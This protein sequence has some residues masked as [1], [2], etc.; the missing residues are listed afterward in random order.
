MQL[1]TSHWLHTP[2]ITMFVDRVTVEVEAGRGGDGCMSFRREKYVPRGGPDGGDGGDGGSVIVVADARR[3]QPRRAGPS[4][5]LEGR[6]RAR[7]AGLQV[8]RPK[9]RGSHHPRAAGHGADRRR[10]RLRAQGPQ[11]AGRA[12][13]RGPRR[14]RRQGEHA[15]QEL[16]PTRPPASTP[17]RRRPSGAASRSS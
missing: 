8:P 16:P 6:A 7:T 15:V 11:R 12:G 2:L 10:R 1:A 5:A 4:Q 17:R 13:V 14:R 3:R 9:R